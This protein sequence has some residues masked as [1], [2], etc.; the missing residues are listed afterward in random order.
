MDNIRTGRF[1]ADLRKEKGWTQVELADKLGVTDKAVSRWETG[2]GFPDISLMKPISETLEITVNE[3]L[4]GVRIDPEYSQKKAD[5]T[6]IQTLS[7]SKEL[8]NKIINVAIFALGGIVLVWSLLFLGYDTS[9]VAV[10]STIGTLIVAVAVFMTLKKRILIAILSVVTVLLL[11]FGISEARDYVYV[12]YYSMPPLYRISI[13]TTFYNGE[14]V[15]KYD[16][17]FYDVY[18]YNADT[19]DEYYVIK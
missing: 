8:V 7:D 9:W 5:D 11:A 6:I 13:L 19:S 10:Y 18:R 12:K 17:V 3:L 14:K 15:I 1:I 2:K 16:K 4:V